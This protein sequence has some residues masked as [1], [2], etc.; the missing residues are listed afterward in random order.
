MEHGVL[1][2]VTE[3]GWQELEPHVMRPLRP[4]RAHVLGTALALTD[5]ETKLVVQ[6]MSASRE[7]RAARMKRRV[8]EG[9]TDPIEL[10]RRSRERAARVEMRRA[11]ALPP[12]EAWR[13]LFRDDDVERRFAGIVVQ[14]GGAVSPHALHVAWGAWKVEDEPMT[15]DPVLALASDVEGMRAV[16][17]IAMDH[18]V[19]PRHCSDMVRRARASARRLP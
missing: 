6:H 9:F 12:A 3:P 1:L 11:R 17:A 15:I 13:R 16:E 4:A 8:A 2:G 10:Q 14:K 18:G 5:F 7:E 19:L